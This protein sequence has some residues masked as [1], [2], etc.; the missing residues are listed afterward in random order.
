MADETPNTVIDAPATPPVTD[1]TPQ[2]TWRDALPETIRGNESLAQFES[3]DKLVETF[4][5]GQADVDPASYGLP[6]DMGHIA[7]MAA[8]N[9]LSKTQ[10]EKLLEFDKAS[11]AATEQKYIEGLKQLETVEWKED[12][13][14]NVDIAKRALTHFDKTGEVKAMLEAT[15]AGNNPAVVKFLHAIG[16]TLQEDSFVKGAAPTGA[17]GKSQADIMYGDTSPKK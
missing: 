17:A 16:M 3:V 1:T 6:E 7:K 4:L 15:R 2:P 14:T 13:K 8:E 5:Q 11:V 10:V 12:F 9:K